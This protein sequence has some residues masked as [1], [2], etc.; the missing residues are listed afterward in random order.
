MS[1]HIITPVLAS[2]LAFA[3][4]AAAQPPSDG[5]LDAALEKTLKAAVAKVAPS[6]VHI[7]TTGALALGRT[8]ASA[9]APPS[10][11]VGIISALDRIWGKA[12]QT[13]AKVSP[14]NYGG[15]LVDVQGRV[16]GI[17]VPA[18]PRGQDETAGHEWYDSG[19]GFA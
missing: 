4:L 10:V 12:V 9:D 2:W 13:D 8:W 17:L 7:Q 14:V 16:Q 6:V 11:S 5:A 3:A 1:R 15:P 19:I 18:S